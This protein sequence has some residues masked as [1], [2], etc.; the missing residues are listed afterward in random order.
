MKKTAHQKTVAFS[1]KHLVPQTMI[2]ETQLKYLPHQKDTGVQVQP[3]MTM[4]SQSQQTVQLCLHKEVQ[5]D[6]DPISDPERCDPDIDTDKESENEN[7]TSEWNEPAVKEHWNTLTNQLDINPFLERKFI[8]YE[9]KLEELLSVC[10]QC[11][12]PST[13]TQVK[14]SVA[15]ESKL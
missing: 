4:T 12:N 6:P 13:I 10:R 8:V 3:T 1:M 15:Q 5:T 2:Y 14:K 11:S 9:K 7:D